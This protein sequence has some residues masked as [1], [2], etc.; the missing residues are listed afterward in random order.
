MCIFWSLTWCL[1]SWN[2]WW[3]EEVEISEHPAVI[4]LWT[5]S[6]LFLNKLSSMMISLRSRRRSMPTSTERFPDSS[7]CRTKSCTRAARRSCL[8]SSISA[9]SNG[10]KFLSFGWSTIVPMEFF[11]PDQVQTTYEL[12]TQIGKKISLE[13]FILG[14]LC[15]SFLLKPSLTTCT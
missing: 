8:T 6:R 15:K 11:L 9:P 5:W 10:P 3:Q 2:G 13:D 14:L 7:S 1:F 4:A 12:V